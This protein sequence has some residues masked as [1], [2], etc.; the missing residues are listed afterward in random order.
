MKQDK[1][2]APMTT[3]RAASE[4]G[5]DIDASTDVLVDESLLLV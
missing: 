3:S 5:V 2:V 1:H 4:R